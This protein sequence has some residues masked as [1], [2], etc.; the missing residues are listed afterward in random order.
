MRNYNTICSLYRQSESAIRFTGCSSR[1]IGACH[2]HSSGPWRGE[3]FQ[4]VIAHSRQQLEGLCRLGAVVLVRVQHHGQRPVGPV[5]VAA[6]VARSQ[7]Q[8]VPVVGRAGDSAHPGGRAR[9]QARPPVAPPGHG[10]RRPPLALPSGT[11]GQ[12]AD[13][14]LGRNR[15]RPRSAWRRAAL[16][17]A[18]PPRREPRGASG[19]SCCL[20]RPAQACTLDLS[21]RSVLARSA[22]QLQK[23][24]PAA[25]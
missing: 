14:R 2:R 9:C 7:A 20:P 15:R 12:T 25:R 19:L 13:T 11:A 5:D 22:A 23:R 18:H 21:V 6:A 10:V 1:A 24:P 8:L 16:P 4:Q 17:R 3:H